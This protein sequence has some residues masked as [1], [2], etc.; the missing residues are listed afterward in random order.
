MSHCPALLH[1]LHAF[2]S[3]LTTNLILRVFKLSDR[4]TA[5]LT[6]VLECSL[7]LEVGMILRVCH[8]GYKLEEYSNLL[9]A[10][11]ILAKQQKTA[12][13]VY[14]ETFNHPKTGQWTAY[15]IT[16]NTIQSSGAISHQAHN[17]KVGNSDSWTQMRHSTSKQT[18]FARLKSIQKPLAGSF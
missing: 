4:Y 14:R 15:C 2:L 9:Q 13:C 16:Y 8:L 11:S 5:Q 3:S 12:H 1:V 6:S 17:R 7:N 10:K 18:T